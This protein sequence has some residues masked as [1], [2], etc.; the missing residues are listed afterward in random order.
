MMIWV[1]K[2]GSVSVEWWVSGSERP[3]RVARVTNLS[4]SQHH[5]HHNH[6]PPSIASHYLPTHLR[7][8]RDCCRDLSACCLSSSQGTTSPHKWSTPATT[9]AD[10]SVPSSDLPADRGVTYERRRSVHIE[11][12]AA[13]TEQLD[14]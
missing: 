1:Q 5:H 12:M 4:F 10:C 2:L 11:G 7:L 8:G 3:N 9:L 13:N 14:R 6:R